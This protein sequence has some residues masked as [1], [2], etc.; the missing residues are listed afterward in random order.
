LANGRPKAEFI[1]QRDLR[2]WDPL[3]PFLFNIVAG[4]LTG[5]MRKAQE[6]NLFEGFKVGSNN[7]DISIYYNMQTT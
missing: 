6:R 4:G 1:P 5:L 3:A 2:Q 7:V